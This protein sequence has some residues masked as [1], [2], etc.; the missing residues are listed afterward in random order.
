M[1]E[2]DDVANH[3]DAAVLG[4]VDQN[5]GGQVAIRIV[6]GRREMMLVDEYTVKAIVFSPGQ[7]FEV[8]F[9]MLHYQLGSAVSISYAHL[10]PQISRQTRVSNFLERKYLHCRTSKKP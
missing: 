5:G 1:T 9:I 6:V 2:R 10:R 3:S 4:P 7:F 8:L